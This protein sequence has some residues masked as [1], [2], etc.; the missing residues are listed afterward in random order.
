MTPERPNRRI[1]AALLILAAVVLVVV[2]W[3]AVSGLRAAI[4]IPIV[5]VAPG[6]GLSRVLRLRIGQPVLALGVAFMLSV[7]LDT[8]LVIVID[9]TG[10]RLTAH[11][12]AVSIGC[13]LVALALAILAEPGGPAA[14][15]SI[16]RREVLRGAVPYV[17][18]VVVAAAVVV[19]YNLLPAQH[20]QPYVSL[21]LDGPAVRSGRPVAARPGAPVDLPVAV[22]N[23]TDVAQSFV[24]RGSATSGT[25]HPVD[26]MLAPGAIWHGAIHGT[27]P[28]VRCT[29]PVTL[30]LDPRTPTPPPVSL[31]VWFTDAGGAT[32]PAN[33][34]AGS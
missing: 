34:A 5:L 6:F 20:G 9:A 2:E 31:D 30:T 8:L 13:V 26:I 23:H 10:A 15:W 28:A 14:P 32:C 17:W 21:A 1:A 24:L 25:W 18:I 22:A 4:A 7:S 16:S 11:D 33:A 19:F 29:T 27:A 3:I 12:A